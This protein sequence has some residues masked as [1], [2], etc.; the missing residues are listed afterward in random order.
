MPSKLDASG[1]GLSVL[2]T[3]AYKHHFNWMAYASWYSVYKNLPNAKVTITCG[4]A[5]RIENYFY[6]WVYKCN[7]IRYNL[8]KNVGD[9]MGV[10]YLNKLYG[11]W[12]AL[13]EGLVKQPLIVLDADM[14][15]MRD[16]SPATV[17]ELN[18]AEFATVPC[19][20]YQL[21]FSGKPVGP[22]WFFNRVPLEKVEEVINTLR[23]LKGRDHL[24]LLA[25]SKVF[26]NDVRVLEDLGSEVSSD[27]VTTFTHYNTVGSFA[28]KDW[29]KGKVV[30][31]FNTAY[32]LQSTRM[33]PNERKVLTLWGQ[34]AE[35]W[36][37]VNQ[38]KI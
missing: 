35:L 32:A 34:M 18:G 8:H 22:L 2:I 20:Y 6:H 16:F 11:V 3:T 21:A 26:G 4:R 19:P 7:D 36:E 28:K 30:P 24:D 9:K 10:P 27:E 25:L 29:E 33:S 13:K 23:T 14:M 12:V 15:A 1:N 5:P 38:I 17:A 37:A 31:P